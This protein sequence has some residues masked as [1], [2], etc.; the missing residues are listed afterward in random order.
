MQPRPAR[1]TAGRGP[2]HLFHEFALPNAKIT[3]APC[4]AACVIAEIP[5]A[6]AP[7]FGTIAALFGRAATHRP[8]GWDA[9]DRD[10]AVFNRKSVKRHRANVDIWDPAAIGA[11]GHVAIAAVGAVI[12][13]RDAAVIAIGRIAI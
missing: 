7:G 10:H 11:V 3:L 4:A 2:Y 1:K 6:N 5:A 13:I 8:R 12:A 9:G